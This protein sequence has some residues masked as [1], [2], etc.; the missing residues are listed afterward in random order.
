MALVSRATTSGLILAELATDETAVSR[1]LKQID[2]DLM[3]W[4]PDAS[5][6]YYRVM[7]RVSDWQPAIPVVAWMDELGNAL[8]LSSGLID[9][10]QKWRPE[11]RGK[12]GPDADEHNRLRH[13]AI[14]RME[15]ENSAAIM[16]DYRGHLERSRTTVSLDGARARPS[17]LR[18]RH[19]PESVRKA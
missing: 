2:E 9:E 3:L 10:V 18:N 6:G 8:P 12:R 1:A 14:R 7:C 19:L 4:P 15:D 11:N 16:D 13:E 17:Y 5:C